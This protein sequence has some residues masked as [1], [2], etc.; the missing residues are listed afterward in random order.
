MILLAGINFNNEA[1][2]NEKVITS[3]QIRRFILVA[4]WLRFLNF[5][6]YVLGV[7]WIN[8]KEV[9]KPLNK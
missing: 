2:S 5:T 4:L 9:T 1:L 7:I 8:F 6:E 3:F